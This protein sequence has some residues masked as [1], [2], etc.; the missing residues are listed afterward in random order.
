[1]RDALIKLTTEFGITHITEQDLLA[2]ATKSMPKPQRRW[3]IDI[4]IDSPA[5]AQMAHNLT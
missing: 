4:P 3:S 1:M 2:F 5:L